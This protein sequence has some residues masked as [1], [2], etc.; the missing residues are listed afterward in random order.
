MIDNILS[1]FVRCAIRLIPFSCVQL[2]ALHGLGSVQYMIWLVHL[3][4]IELG[5]C[6][7]LGNSMAQLQAAPIVEEGDGDALSNKLG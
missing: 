4:E 5:L 6:L 7:I 2:T 1:S 3:G